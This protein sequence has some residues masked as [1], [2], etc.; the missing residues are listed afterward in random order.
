MKRQVGRLFCCLLLVGPGVGAAAAQDLEAAPEAAAATG[1]S[2]STA[3]TVPAAED[4]TPILGLDL[5]RLPADA[6]APAIAGDRPGG[7]GRRTLSAFPKNLGRSFV[8]VF[9][10]ESILP[11]VVGSSA[12]IASH[13]F[14]PRVSSALDGEC[15][16]CGRTGATL[17]GV[18]IV[19]MV[20]LFF[21]A[22]R[23]APTSSTLR[24]ASYDMAQALIVDTAWTGILKY[25]LHR[26]RPDGTDYLSLPSGH[27][28]AAFALATVAERHYGWKAGLPAYALA[29]GIGLSRIESNKH[30]LSDVI[31]GATI[32]T[33]VGRT[34][35]RL[36]GE[37]PSSRHTIAITPATDAHGAGIGL[38]FAA[39]W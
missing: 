8:G 29:A 26:Q 19:P 12:A 13:A 31:A 20:G 27:S 24:A 28:S 6:L 25:S 38:G 9:S 32:G 39:S 4:E 3:P 1:T 36:N 10:R 23:F 37:R 21:T 34:V 17:G 7:D 15:P 14:D 22:G 30:Y 18:A 2:G 35:T 5:S 33:I 11:F 16:S